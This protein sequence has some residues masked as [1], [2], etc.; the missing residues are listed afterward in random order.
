ML[1]QFLFMSK[2]EVWRE[3]K[4]EQLE[5]EVIEYITQLKIS[6]YIKENRNSNTK[7]LAKNI[8][9]IIQEKEKLYNQNN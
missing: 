4:L 1:F 2:T 6:R 8:Q 9:K 5:L 7:E 3:E